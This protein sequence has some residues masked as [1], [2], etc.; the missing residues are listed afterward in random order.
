M[1]LPLYPRSRDYPNISI[2]RATK[3]RIDRLLPLLIA[4]REETEQQVDETFL[5]TRLTEM[6]RHPRRK[7]HIIVAQEGRFPVG[8][9]MGTFVPSAHHLGTVF[10]VQE[11][12]IDKP[13]RGGSVLRELYA[14]VRGY[15]LSHGAVCIEARFP[16]NAIRFR[17]LSEMLGFD[18]TGNEVFEL[19]LS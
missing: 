15:A 3:R 18:P 2:K 1:Q 16:R 19:D 5:I 9:V 14:W 8:Y 13:Y 6:M 12:F 11:L 4:C 7:L 17:S 10:W